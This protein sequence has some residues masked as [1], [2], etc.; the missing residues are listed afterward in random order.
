MTRTLASTCLLAAI[1]I[2]QSA[3]AASKCDTYLRRAGT[4]KGADLVAAWSSLAGCDKDLATANFGEFMRHSEDLETL[5]AL[6]L[7]A[8]DREAYTP[9]WQ[10]MGQVPY[11]FR[12]D[13]AR[14]V[15]A[16]CGT[17]ANIQP[18][19]QGAFYGLRGGDFKRWS[20]AL[21]GCT[22]EGYV[23]WLASAV[24]DPPS[25]SYDE[26]YDAILDAWVKV[27]GQEGLPQLQAAAVKASEGDGPFNMVLERIERAVAPEGYGGELD[28]EHRAILEES[29]VAVARQ[30][31]P[32]RAQQVGSRLF[33]AGSERA[34]ASLLRAAW[35]D[36][37]QSDGTLIYGVAAIESCDN[38][39]VLHWTV[40]SDPGHRWSVLDDV[41][42][43]LLASRARLR[44]TAS[45]DWPVM[46]T[47]TPVANANA[48]EDW[49]ETLLTQW[50]GKV[51]EAKLR[52]EKR[53]AL[54]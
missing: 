33:D 31:G 35:P 24:E 15:G 18:F 49:V 17:H 1:L 29:L 3:A 45:G 30:V 36:H 39:A 13:L 23:T 26:K 52:E 32:E 16:A 9:V 11:E 19:I 5:S 28:A 48:A 53:I 46:V 25:V 43:R 42:P 7:A 22:D 41:T 34:A 51:A 37:V 14:S 4:A 44:C 50:A 8:I 21:T 20:G 10:M 54:D 2:P 12:D 27:R 6:A 47:P 38:Q 40:A